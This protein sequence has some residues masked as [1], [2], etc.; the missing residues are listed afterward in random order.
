MPLI[1]VKNPLHFINSMKSNSLDLVVDNIRLILYTR[2]HNE[3]K[4][5]RYLEVLSSMLTP[6]EIGIEDGCFCS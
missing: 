3:G 5:L 1:D 2:T 6:A 4:I